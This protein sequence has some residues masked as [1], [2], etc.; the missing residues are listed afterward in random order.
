MKI[1]NEIHKDQVMLKYCKNIFLE[2]GVW[3]SKSRSSVYYPEQG[4]EIYNDIEENSFWYKHRNDCIATVARNYIPKNETIFDI[5]GGNGFVSLRLHNEGYDVCLI[6]PDNIG[7]KN[8][9]T[10]GIENLI[11]SS[12]KDAGITEKSLPHV[13]IFDVLEHI[14]NDNSFLKDMYASL[15]PNGTLMLTVPAFNWLWSDEDNHDGHFRRYT[16]CTLEKQLKDAGFSIV[17]STYFFTFLPLPIFLLR[18]IP[19]LIKKKRSYSAEAYTKENK[20]ESNV[21]NRL[22]DFVFKG[23]INRVSTKKT[24]PFGGSILI[25]ARKSDDK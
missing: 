3:H 2:D 18:T 8:A 20:T 4:N 5:G 14:E 15:A 23:E 7:I 10:R 24:L 16:K 6:E 9:R 1:D 21:L 11:C 12:F 22:M 17:Y 13:G 25:L 19:S